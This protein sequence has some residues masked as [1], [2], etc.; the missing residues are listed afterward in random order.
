MR[1]LQWRPRDASVPVLRACYL[2]VSHDR[3]DPKRQTMIGEFIDVRF[4]RRASL[5]E[6]FPGQ[7]L[8]SAQQVRAL[9]DRLI[10]EQDLQTV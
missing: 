5:V 9:R 1:V 2:P 4:V 8:Y 7:A 6:S 10:P 3:F